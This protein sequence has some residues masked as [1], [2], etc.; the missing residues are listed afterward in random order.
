MTPT[1][2]KFRQ[3]LQAGMTISE[4]CTKHNITLHEAFQQIRNR[5]YEK[6]NR[7]YWGGKETS[8]GQTY[9]SRTSKGTYFIRKTVNGK[10]RHFGTYRTL[11]DA[12]LV[13]DYLIKHGWYHQR[14]NSICKKLGVEKLSH[15][16]PRK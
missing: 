11:E 14:L 7:R 1:L 12:V 3:D 10:Y 5:N 16:G 15:R 13:R 4:A 8:T 6:K 9:I 2:S